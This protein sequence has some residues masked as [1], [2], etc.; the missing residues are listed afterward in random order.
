MHIIKFTLEYQPLLLDLME[1]N[2]SAILLNWT[3]PIGVN[4]SAGYCVRVVIEPS[5]LEV[6]LECGIKTTEFIYPLPPRSWC[7]SFVFTVIITNSSGNV[8]EHDTR[9]HQGTNTSPLVNGALRM[10]AAANTFNYS[11]TMVINSKTCSK[12]EWV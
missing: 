6:L 11:L 7:N 4:F 5:D 3:V 12:A 2:E 9:I 1:V 8:G 10:T